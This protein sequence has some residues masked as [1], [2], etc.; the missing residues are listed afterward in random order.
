MFAVQGSG[1]WDGV[2]AGSGDGEDWYECAWTYAL[3]L[4]LLNASVHQNSAIMPV[5]L[6]PR[7][8]AESS[9]P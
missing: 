1:L 3:H 6:L 9:V 7:F 2:A 8:D 5:A 4:P